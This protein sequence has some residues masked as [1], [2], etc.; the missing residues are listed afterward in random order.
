M[1]LKIIKFKDCTNL[2]RLDLSGLKLDSEIDFDG[3]FNNTNL[4]ILN[5]DSETEKNL[6]SKG[7]YPNLTNC[8]KGELCKDCDYIEEISV[9]VKCDEGYYLSSNYK[10]PTK[11]NQCI[12]SNCEIC[13]NEYKCEQC[14]K[15]YNLT[16]NSDLNECRENFS[17]ITSKTV[18]NTNLISDNSTNLI[19]N[20]ED[21]TDNSTISVS[22]LISLMALM[23][24]FLIQ[25]KTVKIL[26]SFCY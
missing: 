17:D 5:L 13:F 7:N 20:N 3:A 9:C 12:I 2:A 18:N 22:I 10:Y 14:K 8:I 21:K 11:C 6:L 26:I 15:G 4:Q 1:L 25:S 19:S 16:S 23:I 24:L